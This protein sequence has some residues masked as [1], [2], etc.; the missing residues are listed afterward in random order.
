MVPAGFGGLGTANNLSVRSSRERFTV[1]EP[2]R[3]SPV[4]RS[5][6][7]G[8]FAQ[9]DLPPGMRSAR[10]S[11]GASSSKFKLEAFVSQGADH[12]DIPAFLRKDAADQ[13]KEPKPMVWSLD[14]DDGRLYLDTIEYEGLT[15]LGLFE[16]VRHTVEADWPTTYRGLIKIGVPIMVVDWLELLLA[17]EAGAV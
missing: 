1:I 3:A 9:Y 6:P 4:S 14:V 16:W 11:M 15:P 17:V 7:F 8:D 2:L 5:D 10:Y 13:V 12:Y